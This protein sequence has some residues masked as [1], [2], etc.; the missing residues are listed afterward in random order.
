M[1]TV[2]FVVGESWDP[3]R[4]SNVGLAVLGVF[5]FFFIH[6]SVQIQPFLYSIFSNVHSPFLYLDGFKKASK[7]IGKAFNAA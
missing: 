6:H 1:Q 4:N 5:F 2:I 3:L 7:K